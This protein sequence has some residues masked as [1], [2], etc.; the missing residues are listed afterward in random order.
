MDIFSNKDLTNLL[1]KNAGPCISIFM[2]TK[3]GGSPQDLIRLRNNLAEAK[4]ALLK[5]GKRPP[6]VE[7]VL[8]PVRQ[9]LDD[10]AFW[11]HQSTGLALF[12]GANYFRRYRLPLN[13]ENLVVVDERFHVVPLLPVLANNGRF[14]ILALSQHAIRL[15]L[16]SRFDVSEIDLSGVPHDLDQAGMTHEKDN[17]FTFF[18]RRD[19]GGKLGEGIFHG[20]GVGLDEKK[21]EI[22]QYFHKVDR[23]VHKLLHGD[24]TPLVLAA[25]HYLQPIYR[26]ANSHPHLLEAGI[27][28]NPERLSDR[29]LH[30]L[31][32]KQIEPEF[33]AAQ[34][35]ALGQYRQMNGTG[36]T[37]EGLEEILSAAHAGRIDTLFIPRGRREWGLFHAEIDKVECHEPAGAGDEEL[38]NLAAAETLKHG[39]K[40]IVLEPEQIPTKK[41]CAA[42]L[43]HPMAKHGKRP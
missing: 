9:L 33:A 8:A 16:G 27:D 37:M 7:E 17:P 13:F 39:H 4:D 35:R 38:L 15:L 29:E 25:V 28:G 14:Y 5:S 30:D 18:G 32:W 40:V 26:E 20:H 11:K 42:I 23:G 6:E 12:V 1:A 34:E 31:A 41:L 36:L 10:A 2:P 21:N 24:Q 22:L 3:R 43:C 19:E